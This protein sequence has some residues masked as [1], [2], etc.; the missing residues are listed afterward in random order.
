MGCYH[1]Q[2]DLMLHTELPHPPFTLS[3]SQ[4]VLLMGSCFA[5]SIG[6][7]LQRDKFACL[8]NPFG[9]LYN[10]SAMAAHLFRCVSR[11]PYSTAD[12]WQ[13]AD[14]L[15][16][17]WMHHGSFTADS[18]EELTARLNA[19]LEQAAQWLATTDV[20]IVTMGTSV[21]YRLRESG[22]LVANCH[23][24]PDVLFLR[25]RLAAVDI[26][27]TWTTLLQLLRSVRPELQVVLT[28]SPVRHK[29]DGLHGNQLSK[30]ELLLACDAL[31]RQM[32]EAVT[33]FPAFELL[34]DE[35][36]DYRFY[37]PD[38]VHPTEQ[39]ADY[40][41]DRFRQCFISEAEERISAQ[42]RAVAEALAHRPFR[43]DGEEYQQL[44]QQQMV[45]IR[46]LAEKYPWI[47]FTEETELCLTRLRK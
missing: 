14:G 29:R 38:M 11:R 34:T 20:L 43:P 16:R 32:P 1:L 31:C 3:H 15:W 35:L 17:S 44:L 37:A 12:V 46:Q 47:D 33:Y 19:T 21:V 9:T 5:D 40:I 2:M 18:A 26:V 10:P 13:G 24:Q 8:V 23:R 4:R 42:C 6:G 27:D 39:A 30:A 36:R 22:S 7:R 41:Y 28:V 45:H 25:E